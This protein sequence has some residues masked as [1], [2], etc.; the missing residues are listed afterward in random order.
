MNPNPYTPK[1]R[2]EFEAYCR[3]MDEANDLVI[4]SAMDREQTGQPV[5]VQQSILPQYDR[6]EEKHE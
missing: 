5:G 2:E 6:T 4:K 1:T 3:A